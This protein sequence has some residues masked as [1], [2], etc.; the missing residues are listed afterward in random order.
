MGDK[1]FTPP[2]QVKVGE[3]EGKTS[4]VIQRVVL[5]ENKVSKVRWII[6]IRNNRGRGKKYIYICMY[7]IRVLC[8]SPVF[9]CAIF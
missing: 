5:S 7:Y 8:A 2:F 1:A 3:H 4:P 9:N 6:I